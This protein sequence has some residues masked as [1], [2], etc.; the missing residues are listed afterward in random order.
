MTI[1]YHRFDQNLGKENLVAHW[2]R[3]LGLCKNEEWIWLFSDDDLMEEHCV[4]AFQSASISPDVNVIHYALTFIDENGN[5]VRKTSD[6][7][8]LLSSAGFFDLLFRRQIDA[9]MQ[10]FVFRRSFL[11]TKG[12][13]FFPLAWRT[14]T[15]TVMSAA[16]SGG[17]QTIRDGTVFWRMSSENIS[18]QMDLTVKKNEANISF[19]NWTVSFYSEQGATLPMSKFY[20]AKTEVFALEYLSLCQLFNDA[21]ASTRA[22]LPHKLGRIVLI[23]VLC[24]YRWFYRFTE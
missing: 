7:P 23:A 5:L 21:E 1:H 14:D 19:F 13:V 6:F 4:E 3:C 17:I 16:I 10:D 9:R 20:L 24:L 11:D 2:T 22:L 15:A 8:D 12:L 18:G